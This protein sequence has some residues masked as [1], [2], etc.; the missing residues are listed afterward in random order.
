MRSRVC[1]LVS[2]PPAGLPTSLATHTSER[3]VSVRRWREEPTIL[4][5]EAGGSGAMPSAM[6]RPGGLEP[7]ACGL[8]N[9]CS[10][11]LSYG[12]VVVAAS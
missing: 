2:R 3:F 1:S 9:R 10:I 5:I 6:V 7:P 11:Q 4:V 12:R 8:G